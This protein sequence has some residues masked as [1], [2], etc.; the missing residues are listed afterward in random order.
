M[1]CAIDQRRG[2]RVKASVGECNADNPTRSATNTA[3][4]SDKVNCALIATEFPSLIR[5]DCAKMCE[6]KRLKKDLRLWLSQTR[7][8]VVQ[9]PTDTLYLSHTEDVHRFL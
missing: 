7:D 8:E 2:S 5:P 3:T 9:S 6:Y 4:G 1:G